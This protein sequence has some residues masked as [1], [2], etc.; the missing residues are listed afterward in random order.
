M[1]DIF[2]RRTDTFG[3]SL[4]AD[5]SRMTFPALT[6]GGSD[7][8]FMMQQ[9]NG[10]YQQQVTRV[11][12]IGSPNVYYIGGRTAGTLGSQRIVGPRKI[13]REFYLTYGD[14]CKA[15]TNSLQISAQSGC[16]AGVALERMNYSCHFVVVTQVGF[17][18]AAQDNVINESLQ[19]MFSSL[20][21]T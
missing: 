1:S 3:G 18:M 9:L 6:G 4:S 16:D 11:Y 19:M 7:S 10:N 13:A 20:I 5:G 2:N 12:E 17:A 8:G 21:Y 14:V 15:R